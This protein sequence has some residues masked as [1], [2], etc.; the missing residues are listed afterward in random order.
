MP[1]AASIAVKGRQ[2]RA[3]R[4]GSAAQQARAGGARVGKQA[5]WLTLT[6]LWAL[7][8]AALLSFDPLDPPTHAAAVAH[9][10]P[11]NWAGGVGAVVAHWL[12]VTLG[13]GVWI[14][15]AAW[16]AALVHT[17]R[18]RRLEQ[19]LLT[20]TGLAMLA[21]A[22]SAFVA[23]FLPGAS[24]LPEG[25]GGLLGIW[26]AE[27]LTSRFGVF[28]ASVWLALAATVGALVS[29]DEAIA[30][31]GRRGAALAKRGLRLVGGRSSALGS[32]RAR[33][34]VRVNDVDDDERPRALLRGEKTASSGSS[35]AVRTAPSHAA[36]QSDEEA[37]EE[38]AP[39]VFDPDQLRARI[40]KLPVR[41][42]GAGA[43]AATEEDIAEWR[44]ADDAALEGYR[45]PGL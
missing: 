14:F 7:L 34:S 15:D 2:R 22:L 19:P 21:I 33:R 17:L 32:L 27:Q 23:I 16:L 10:T 37:T 42:A 35:S 45:F 13:P 3:A 28:G 41:F 36:P 31:A 12:I 18:G 30:Q 25:A 20:L 11:H 38:N 24:A 9:P 29:A 43:K 4:Q 5:L 44:L 8:T 39:Q 26:T 40:A 6:A 1:A